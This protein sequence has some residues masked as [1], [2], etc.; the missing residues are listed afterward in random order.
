MALADI[1]CSENRQLSFACNPTKT[2]TCAFRSEKGGKL[3]PII[4]EAGNLSAGKLMEAV[5]S[6]SLLGV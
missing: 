3:L 4:K 6:G 1:L 2:S 5:V